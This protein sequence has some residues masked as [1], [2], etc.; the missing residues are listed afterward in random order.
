MK[1]VVPP[2]LMHLLHRAVIALVGGS[3]QLVT[4]AHHQRR[5]AQHGA[6]VCAGGRGQRAVAAVDLVEVIDDRAAVDQR[7]AVVEH[8]RRDAA[9]R[10]VGANVAAVVEA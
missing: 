4:G 9:E 8:E 10:I 5:H 3:E 1:A 7:L 6:P 2:G